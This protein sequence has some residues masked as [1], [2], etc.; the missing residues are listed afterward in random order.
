[1]MHLDL[2]EKGMLSLASYKIFKGRIEESS[3]K[4]FEILTEFRKSLIHR[5]S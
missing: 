2:K 1:M 4:G 3:Q 5:K